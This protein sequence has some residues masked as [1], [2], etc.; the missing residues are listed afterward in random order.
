VLADLGIDLPEVL[1][2]LVGV[3][4]AHYFRELPR[5]SLFEEVGE[6]GVNVGLHVA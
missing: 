2:D 4:A 1:V 5:R 3:I 6:L